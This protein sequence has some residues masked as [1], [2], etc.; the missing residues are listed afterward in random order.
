MLKVL[1]FSLIMGLVKTQIIRL[2]PSQGILVPA[3]IAE[4]VRITRSSY[5]SPAPSVPYS[6][7]APQYSRPGPAPSSSYKPSTI[8]A[9]PC[10]RNY[11]FSCQPALTPAPCSAP[12][13]ASSYSAP[14]QGAYSS[15]I[16][17]YS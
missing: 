8:S 12:A 15:N 3:P 14:L 2:E 4:S 10:P 6:Q 16:P 11:I 7:P 9:L 5:G 17:Q 1:I 13:P